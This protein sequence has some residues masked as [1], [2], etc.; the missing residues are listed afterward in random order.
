MTDSSATPK[1]I[2]SPIPKSKDNIIK[3]NPK[4]TAYWAYI[5]T[6]NG[7]SGEII[8]KK[9]NRKNDERIKKIYGKKVYELITSDP[10]A[11][12]KTWKALPIALENLLKSKLKLNKKETNL[13][14]TFFE[15]AFKD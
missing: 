13:L 15:N 8:W 11:L 7:K 14:I 5:I 10:D 12:Q 4:A 3:N 1:P 6:K 2:P 9:K